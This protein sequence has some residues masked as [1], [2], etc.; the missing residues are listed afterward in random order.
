MNK[1]QR[2][3]NE[4]KNM[5]RDAYNLDYA[6]AKWLV[7]RLKLF[8]KLNVAHPWDMTFEDWQ[9]TVKEIHD[10]LEDFVKNEYDADLENTQRSLR[11][12]ADNFNDLWI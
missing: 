6:L 1:R 7:P 9:A 8:L 5:W 10:G 12:L 4:K 11:L 3:K 2:K